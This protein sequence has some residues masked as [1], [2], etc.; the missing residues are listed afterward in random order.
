[1]GCS[2][3]QEDAQSTPIDN[4]PIIAC[5]H[6]DSACDDGIRLLPNMCR[7]WEGKSRWID[8]WLS[9]LHAPL[10]PYMQPRLA[11]ARTPSAPWLAQMCEAPNPP[12]HIDPDIA[13]SDAG[14]ILSGRSDAFQPRHVR[15]LLLSLFS[16]STAPPPHTVC[17]SRTIQPPI[18]DNTS[19]IL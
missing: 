4:R 9:Y 19:W 18:F 15:L 5:K 2:W 1:M 13:E 14:R 11:N 6:V 16:L 12:H 8:C 3:G 10:F 7:V 17:F